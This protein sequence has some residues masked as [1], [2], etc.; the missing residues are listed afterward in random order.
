MSAVRLHRE[1]R[2]A[3]VICPR[4]TYAAVVCQP[5]VASITN[6][7][8]FTNYSAI[9]HHRAVRTEVFQA[10]LASPIEE[11]LAMEPGNRRLTD[12]DI[13]VLCPSN[14]QWKLILPDRHADTVFQLNLGN[15]HKQVFWSVS[16]H[17][18]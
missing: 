17:Y 12:S 9:I 10:E 13:A 18:F 15:L 14:R 11:Q 3:V 5:E 1:K 8:R 7:H 16:L 2:D 4:N 6:A